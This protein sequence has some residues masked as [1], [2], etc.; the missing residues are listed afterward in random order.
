MR[1]SFFPLL[2]LASSFTSVLSA[3]APAPAVVARADFNALSLVSDLQAALQPDIA[4]IQ[5]TATSVNADST[6]EEKAAASS[7][8]AAS[9]TKLTAAVNSADAQIPTTASKRDGLEKRQGALVAPELLAILTPLSTA[10]DAVVSS[11]GLGKFG[12]HATCSLCVD[13]KANAMI[14]DTAL[15]L[16][17]PLST[18][19][20]KLIRDLETVVDD[21]LAVVKQLLD[22]LLGGLSAGLAGIVL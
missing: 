15:N 5:A 14:A 3:P 10:S 11:L 13:C 19:L 1:T 12:L 21:L 16:F 22:G 7:S 17:N 8:I 6:D 20:S 2:A 4:A 18:S 9:V